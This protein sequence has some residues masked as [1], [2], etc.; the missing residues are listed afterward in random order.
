M[1]NQSGTHIALTVEAIG[2]GGVID[3][4]PSNERMSE[5]QKKLKLAVILLYA[6]VLCAAD[7]K[8]LSAAPVAERP[9]LASLYAQAGRIT[10]GRP[11]PDLDKIIAIL[12]G[13]IRNHQLPEK[14][15]NKLAAMNGEE[16]RLVAMLCDRMAGAGADV[17]FLLAAA[18]IVLT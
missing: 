4:H 13:R 5:M 6:V 16:L 17:A 12:E 11:E 8:D 14:A 9:G 15:R 7:G 1:S 10:S 2:T 3:Q 18:L